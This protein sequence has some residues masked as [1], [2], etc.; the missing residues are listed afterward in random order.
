MIS[1]DTLPAP[2]DFISMTV[3]YYPNERRTLVLRE[4]KHAHAASNQS[5][6]KRLSYERAC[7]LAELA[8]PE[9]IGCRYYFLVKDERGEQIR[10][11]SE[12]WEAYMSSV[13][14]TELRVHALFPPLPPLPTPS[15]VV[16]ERSRVVEK[17]LMVMAGYI[18]FNM[19]QDLYVLAVHLLF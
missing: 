13:D 16:E 5:K 10:I 15:P 6:N 3:D 4:D 12:A 19:M 17:L 14:V 1:E 7:Q 11:C 2:S 9:I 8:F 18:A